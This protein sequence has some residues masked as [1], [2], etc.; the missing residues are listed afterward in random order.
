MYIETV[1]MKSMKSCLIFPLGVL[2]CLF[3]SCSAK[4]PIVIGFVGGLTGRIAD[5]GIA[6]RDGVI[7]AVEEKNREGGIHGRPVELIVKDDAQDPNRAAK[8]DTELI[9]E[10]VAA[11]IGHMTSSM[12]VVAVPVMNEHK[13]LMISP[14]TSTNEL[15]GRDDYFFRVYPYSAQTSTLLAQYVYRRMGLRKAASVYD[16]TNRD[17]T[18]SAF[19]PFREEFERL[20]GGVVYVETF[21]SGPQVQ[22]LEIA[23]RAIA[24]DPDCLYVLANAMDTAMIS[25]QLCKLGESLQVVTSDWSATD[26]VLQYGGASVEGMFFM[27]TVNRDY[28]EPRYLEFKEAFQA[29]FAYEPGF[30]SIHAYDAAHILFQALEQNGDPSLLP[31]TIRKIEAFQGLQSEIRFDAFGDVTRTHFPIQVRD[32]H[33]VAVE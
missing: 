18:E 33:F 4:E 17:H 12:S 7:L 9:A 28:A 2:V 24:S 30:A 13:V 20:G 19:K 16:V 26:E 31:E 8:V 23:K 14:T 11:I 25:Q 21:L 6:G 1:N 15:T 5:L 22:F 32:G 27:H 29:R 10:G 3:L